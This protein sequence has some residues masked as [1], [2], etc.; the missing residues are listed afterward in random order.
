M[1]TLNDRNAEILQH[2]TARGNVALS[3]ANIRGSFGL[4]ACIVN[5]LTTDEDIDAVIAEVL[6]AAEATALHRPRPAQ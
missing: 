3:N 6:P 4:R 5:H 2:V 1:D